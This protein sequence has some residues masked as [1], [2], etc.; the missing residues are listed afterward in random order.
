MP[1]STSPAGAQSTDPF[2]E[3][4][5]SGSGANLVD[6]AAQPLYPPEAAR[7][8]WSLRDREYSFGN[9]IANGWR[10]GSGSRYVS[11]HVLRRHLDS[12]Q[13]LQGLDNRCYELGSAKRLAVCRRSQPKQNEPEH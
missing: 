3:H 2:E 8:V 13:F 1:Q 10:L 9:G 5:E 6:M 12:K 11:R 7:G 4:L